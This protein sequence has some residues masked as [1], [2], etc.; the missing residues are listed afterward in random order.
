[1]ST[2]MTLEQMQKQGRA[3]M[4]RPAH[5]ICFE[6]EDI[7]D[8]HT[9]DTWKACLASILESGLL[10]EKQPDDGN[11]DEDSINYGHNT[12]ARDIKEFISNMNSV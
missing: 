6:Q 4:N 7:L 12:L 1:M 3:K 11:G 9:A 8:Q 5:G 10:E 2:P